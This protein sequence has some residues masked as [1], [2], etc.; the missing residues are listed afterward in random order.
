MRTSW[1]CAQLSRRTD[2]RLLK[3]IGT[4]PAKGNLVSVSGLD[5]HTEF[6][7]CH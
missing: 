6:C 7:G 5:L 4:G 3:V 2:A 1:N